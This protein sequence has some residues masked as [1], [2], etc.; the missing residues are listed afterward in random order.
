MTKKWFQLL[1]GDFRKTVWRKKI[2]ILRPGGL[3]IQSQMNHEDLENIKATL[4]GTQDGY[5]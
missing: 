4:M 1:F 3:T 5:F 2:Y